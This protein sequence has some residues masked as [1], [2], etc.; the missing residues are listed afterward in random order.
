MQL[1]DQH[2]RRALPASAF[3]EFLESE[4]AQSIPQRF[5]RQAS[6]YDAQLA[7]RTRDR[8]LSYGELNRLANR[9]AHAVLAELGP[10]RNCV[11][12]LI[13]QGAGAIAAILGALKAGKIYV[14][15]D[16]SFPLARNT[17]ILADAEPDAVISSSRY[18]QLASSLTAGRFPVIDIGELTSTLAE[19]NPNIAIAPDQIAYIMYTSGSSGQ[20]K[21]V[22]QSHRNVLNVVSR[23]TN[24][25]CLTA[26][27]R[28]TLLPSTSVTASVGNIF[29]ALLNGA[30]L[31]PF[32]VRQKG[33]DDLAEWLTCHELTI[34]H[35][36]PTVF[37]HFAANLSGED[38]FPKLRLIRLGSAPVLKSD[39]E[40]YRTH[41]SGDCVFVNG[42]GA[43]EMS[44]AS[45]YVA[46]QYSVI[47][48][49]LVPIGWPL[50][51]TRIVLLDDD[52]K[53]API[54]EAGEI[55]LYSPHLALGY[56]RQPEL[57]AE[58]F[59]TA[60]DGGRF[61]LTGDMG[62][63]SADGCIEHVGRK[64]FQ[65]KIRGYRIETAEIELA[66][67]QHPKVRE[68]AVV[69][70]DEGN[71]EKRLIAYIVA[72]VDSGED[73]SETSVELRSHLKRALPDY[74]LPSAFVVVDRLP[75]TASGKLDRKALPAPKDSRP[76]LD[77]HYVAP[78]TPTEETLAKIFAEVLK[79]ERVG[80]HDDF[81]EL[82]GHSLLVTQVMSY[83]RREFQV[84][85]PFGALFEAPTV[86]DISARVANNHALDCKTR[87]GGR[88]TDEPIPASFSQA[89]L[90][91]LQEYDRQSAAYNR[92]EGFLLRGVIDAKA[93]QRALSGIVSRH[94]CLR[95]TFTALNGEPL[96]VI[97]APDEFKLSLIDLSGLPE[98]ERKA[99]A[100]R[101]GEMEAAMPY[102][103]AAGP[104]I[105]ASLFA[106]KDD[107]HVLIIQMH[108]IV[109]DGW[110]TAIFHRELA[111]IYKSYVRCDP[112]SLPDLAFQYA[113]Y[114]L[115]QRS[116][117]KGKA[118]V[119]QLAYWKRKL[120]DAPALLEL[121]TDRRRPIVRSSNGARL[122][123]M[124][125]KSLLD[126][127]KIL[128]RSSRVTLFMTLLAAF[129]VL[130][131]RY[132]RSDDIV[133]GSPIAGR[134]RAETEQLIGFFVNSLVYRCD[135][136]G[137]PTFKELL[138]RV[139]ATA[140]EAYAHHDVP[141][142][143]LFG[144][145][146][147]H[148]SLSY[149]PIFQ[150]LFVLQNT[151]SVP[152]TLEGATA[153]RLAL[154]RGAT[155]FDLTLW[156][157]E[158]AEG[159]KLVAEYSTDL[160][161]AA[162]IAR[163]IGH[164]EVLLR[165]VV[166]NSEQRLSA[167]PILTQEERRTLLCDFNE[168]G[169]RLQ[170][171]KTIAQ[172]FE[173]QV[174]RTPRNIA[175]VCPSVSSASAVMAG[176]AE[177]R[178]L[179]YAELNE[180]ANRLAHY[181]ISLGA[182]PEVVVGLCVER[183]I[184]VI[185]SL[186]AI[187]KTG[188]AYLP[189]DPNYPKE[190][191]AFML[192]DSNVPILI[193]QTSL[194]ARLARHR[195]RLVLTDQSE[196][197]ASC[198]ATNPQ[199]VAKADNVA[200]VIYTSGSTG[201]PKGVMVE[202]RSLANYS[203]YAAVEY[204][205][206]ADDRVLQ[207][208]SL[209]FDASAEEIYPCL[210]RGA[211]LVLRDDDM[212]AS[213]AQFFE[214]CREWQLTVLSLPTAWWHDITASVIPERLA[215]PRSL[216]LV[217]IGGEAAAAERLASWQQWTGSR[218]EL[219]NTYGPTEATVVATR[220]KAPQAINNLAAVPIGR[221]IASTQIYILDPHLNPVPIGVP[222]ELHIGGVGL[223][224][225][226]LNRPELTKEKFIPNP[227][228]ED[229]DSRLYKT[230]DL[231]RYLPD[232]NIELLGRLD[233]QVK[234]RGFRI[235]LGEIEAALNRHPAVKACAVIVREDTPGDKRL[236][237]Y[238]VVAEESAPADAMLRDSLKQTLPDYMLPSAFVV[239]DQLPLTPNG[240]LDRKA[241]PAPEYRSDASFVAPCTPNDQTLAAIWS[242]VLKIEKIG[243]HDNFFDLG[244]HSLL[245]TQVISRVEKTLGAD[246][247]LRALFESPTVAGL[248]ALILRKQAEAL[249]DDELAQLLTEAQGEGAQP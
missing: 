161:D 142:E 229:L 63:M 212:L 133:V 246:I 50:G 153:E 81:F 124:L 29:G 184:D 104:L 174:N 183:S 230:G 168:T 137:D 56:W 202:H 97:H 57:T 64:D 68:A 61:Y 54:G 2:R 22:V 172:L 58:A 15:L 192:E 96:Q 200:Y 28:F 65:V 206:R 199:N 132:T 170:N 3:V 235:E 23:Y 147:F 193:S 234:I 83:V 17:A 121:P 4:T 232:G 48:G 166:S 87:H 240:K 243:I 24:G 228:S 203:E 11:A 74:M 130:L 185:V 176:R 95:T 181:L 208:A 112:I 80:I 89:R 120:A 109:A 138:G 221:P 219:I 118:L 187:L 167:L 110:S 231:A 218:I 158:T 222:G 225:G 8:A 129:Q 77:A 162:T 38:L 249:S 55:A 214:N 9:V 40:L 44:T 36:V 113:D 239:L 20:P 106:L 75:L 210:I 224:R 119:T 125:G 84:E 70:R 34:Y 248:S 245:A 21:G 195:A 220:W 92:V 35:S 116:Y 62:R 180:K 154:R 198:P 145:L 45:Q 179:S 90:W 131:S 79:I 144:E 115:W 30:A 60:D 226:Y 140:L 10:M 189:L 101:L 7:V 12:I 114:A 157:D 204:G 19:T 53:P 175:L 86:E 149:T 93:L 46:D 244:G 31:F 171:D 99:E 72:A 13:E 14:P 186:L 25:A 88:D 148:R 76:D 227:F 73:E 143:Q 136:S 177:S 178:T 108:H 152:L 194:A 216:R 159:L 241:L 238:V 215:I 33:V 32:D 16:P 52:R 134:T 247:P 211:T 188:A 233:H 37:R 155:K 41:F 43:S 26:D 197:Y 51:D 205:L 207:F 156:A 128:S 169:L 122:S 213:A 146:K 67:I 100:L 173:G 223:A 103:L 196:I 209:N 27:D 190:R 164:Y 71:G 139:R 182:G 98:A 18:S 105:R 160:F 91:F 49:P 126:S 6:I 135:L 150:V 127:V 165:G 66:L 111:A 217:I 201:T 107:E 78:R 237:A 117:L 236:V 163:L 42:Y 94:E 1:Y 102:D 151:P 5:E 242:E 47:T 123:R 141:F 69:G 39:F 82:G 59:V 85:L 191:L